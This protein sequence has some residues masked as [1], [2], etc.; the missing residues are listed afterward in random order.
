MVVAL[1]GIATF[2]AVSCDTAGISGTT[3]EN[4]IASVTLDSSRIVQ[5]ADTVV[6]YSPGTEALAYTDPQL[7]IGPASGV[8]TDVVVLGRGGS[9]TLSFDEPIMDTDGTDFAVWENGIPGSG[10]SLFAELAFVEVSMTGET[11]VRFPTRTFRDTPVGPYEP[12]EPSDYE[13]F[14]GLHPAGTGTAFDL[15]EVDLPEARYIRIIDV[16]GDGNT[17]ADDGNPIYDPYPTVTTAG[18]DLDGVAVLR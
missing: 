15:R 3:P 16:V 2:T 10:N 4:D 11:W 18:F 7:A 9:I 12:I 17:I 13:G 5:W 1:L 8:P 6:D 14:A